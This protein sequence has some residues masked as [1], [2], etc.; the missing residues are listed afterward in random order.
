MNIT[1]AGQDFNYNPKEKDYE[2]GFPEFF[3]YSC[4]CYFIFNISIWSTIPVP[5]RFLTGRF[6][7]GRA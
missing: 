1:L 7:A 6:E 4:S 3:F 5:Y 2:K